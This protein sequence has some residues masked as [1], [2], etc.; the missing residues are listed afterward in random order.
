MSPCRFAHALREA[1]DVL[2]DESR[3]M[4]GGDNWHV[5][6]TY[7][8]IGSA[9]TLIAGVLDRCISEGQFLRA[10]AERLGIRILHDNAAQFFGLGGSIGADG[11]CQVIILNYS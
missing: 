11:A 9:R 8:A 2:P 7:G 1:I 3:M 4:L 10:D 6:E 5:E